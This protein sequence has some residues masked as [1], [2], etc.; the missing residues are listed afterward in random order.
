[1]R[2]FFKKKSEVE[3]EKLLRLLCEHVNLEG[4]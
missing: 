1:M 2:A 4:V 3:V